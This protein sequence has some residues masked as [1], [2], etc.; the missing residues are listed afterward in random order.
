M[1]IM[2]NISVT[3][4]SPEGTVYEDTVLSLTAQNKTG[5]FDI[6]PMHQDFISIIFG[7]ISIVEKNNNIKNFEFPKAVIKIKNN[8]V[9]IFIDID[10]IKSLN[11][12]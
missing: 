8:K 7:E 2:E 10:G 3:I 5:K 12:I 1:N 6:L 4:K 11:T 9:E